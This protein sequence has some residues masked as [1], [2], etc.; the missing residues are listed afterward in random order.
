MSR[1]W[2]PLMLLAILISPIPLTLMGNRGIQITSL[3]DS[4]I[5]ADSSFFIRGPTVNMVT[6]E[7]AMIFWRTEG[8]T[9]ATVWYG[10]NESVI[11]KIENTTLDINHRVPLIGLDIDT[12]YFYKVSSNNTESQL[13][14]FRTAPADGARFRMIIIGDNRPTLVSYIQPEEFKELSQMIVDEDPHI[15][16][17]SGDYVLEV[18]ENHEDNL[19][20]WAAFTNI[21]DSIGHYAPI[22]GALGNHDTGAKTGTLNLDYYFD[23][24]EQYDEPSTYFSFD[25]AG[26]H[27]IFLDTEQ[28]YLEGRITG[29]QYN[30]LV[31]DLEST[32]CP[33]KYVIGHRP[34]YPLN[35][36][37][38][39]ID[40]KP[41]ERIRLQQLFE[42]HN[43]TAYICGHDHLFN[44]L[45]VNGLVHIISGGG[46]APLVYTQW[47][48]AYYHYT[49]VDSSYNHV[50]ISSVKLSGEIG[51]N[52]QL[53]YTG[54][55]E[56][57]LRAIWNGSSK[58][59]NTLPEIYFSE[60]PIEKYYCWDSVANQTELIGLPNANGLHT[61]DVYAMNSDEV[62]SHDRFVFTTVG[63]TTTTTQT[64]ASF[65][66]E[67]LV[68]GGV[69]V[70]GVVIVLIL[71][72]R[73]R[74]P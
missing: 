49:R 59:P 17:M 65:P 63:A 29:D 44:R 66:L 70:A 47:G 14:H 12:R 11:E 20:G 3:V 33:M 35:H 7:S 60:I 13:Y 62:W 24:F 32:D 71:V 30:W 74:Q 9:N 19:A 4:A 15:V 39:S 73:R 40:S 37:G 2:L 18:N 21:S 46:G 22:Y 34:M 64:T 68:I 36:L 10:L 53:P 25:Y 8:V 41:D 42:E 43:V 52:Y 56:I 55:I 58:Q 61:L 57:A 72:Y 5:I 54:P 26:V 16:V 23:A 6:N 45:T 67:S 69:V 51:H 1:T 50:N 48:G 31:N 28:Q 27:F 38:D